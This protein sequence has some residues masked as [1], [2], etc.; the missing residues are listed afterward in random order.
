MDY[1]YITYSLGVRK[2]LLFSSIPYLGWVDRPLEIYL[3]IQG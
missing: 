1:A 3:F 2:D